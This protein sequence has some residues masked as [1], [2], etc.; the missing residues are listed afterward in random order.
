MTSAN[1]AQNKL[2]TSLKANAK[3]ALNVMTNRGGQAKKSEAISIVLA[4]KWQGKL[5]RL[6]LGRALFHL[7]R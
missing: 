4:I 6:S 3:E 7:E 5:T 1:S 2:N